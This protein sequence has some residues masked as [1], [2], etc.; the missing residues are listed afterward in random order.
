MKTEPVTP[1]AARTPPEGESPAASESPQPNVLQGLISTQ[2]LLSA[3]E[4]VTPWLWQGYLAPGLVTLLTSQW[5]SGKTTLVAVLLTRLQ[6]GGV[7]AGLP[8]NPGRAIVVSEE[9]HADWRRRCMQLGLGSQVEFLCRPFAGKPSMAQWLALVDELARLRQSR[10]LDLV[11]ID[12]LASFTPGSTENSAAAMMAYLLPLQRLTAAGISVLLV[13]HP[14]KGPSQ[15]GQAARGSGALCGFVDVLL[16]MYWHG[17]PTDPDRRRRLYGYS[18]HEETPQQVTIELTADG[19]DYRLCD[20]VEDNDD[21]AEHWH[22]LVQVFEDAVTKLTRLE[23]LAGWP[24]ECARPDKATVWRWLELAVLRGLVRRDGLG[25]KSA[26]FR[27]WLP[28]REPLMRPDEGASDEELQAWNERLLREH[29][30]RLEARGRQTETRPQARPARPSGQAVLAEPAVPA[31]AVVRA[32][33]DET[34]AATLPAAEQTEVAAGAAAPGALG[35]VGEAT[36][37]REG[38]RPGAADGPGE[39]EPKPSATTPSRS[40]AAGESAT[41]GCPP[42]TLAPIV[43]PEPD[44]AALEA[45]RRSRRWPGG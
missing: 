18:R 25:K 11:V 26:P 34:G 19:T 13:H 35:G 6:H 17:R 1:I 2:E 23:I 40:A 8:V 16:E 28:E 37:A 30:Q 41:A 38:G 15:A 10:P 36:P 42:F 24:K 14:R 33:A 3:Q 43:P 32:P 45:R 7:L 27:Y 31:T 9:R 29:L 20:D 4:K 12:T 39:A 21:F 5:K 22:A 44:P